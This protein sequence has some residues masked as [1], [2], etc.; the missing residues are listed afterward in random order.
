M[1]GEGGARS[2]ANL[3]LITLWPRNMFIRNESG[4]IL[5]LTS[6][7][8]WK[9]HFRRTCLGT[10]SLSGSGSMGR[11]DNI[12]SLPHGLKFRYSCLAF[13]TSCIVCP[14]THTTISG[15]PLFYRPHMVCIENHCCIF[16]SW[17]LLQNLQ[18]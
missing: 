15:I 6:F 13:S 17:Q 16:T 10:R 3:A 7:N 8:L 14:P 1:Y 18:P 9:N 4:L 11:L 2:L 12:F 5:P